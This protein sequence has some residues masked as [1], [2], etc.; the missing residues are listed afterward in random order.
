L[1]NAKSFAKNKVKS[2]SE[3]KL[4]ETKLIIH[5]TFFTFVYDFGC[6]LPPTCI[7]GFLVR[8]KELDFMPN[9]DERKE[10]YICTGG[11]NTIKVFKE[12]LYSSAT[13]P[14]ANN[15]NQAN[16]STLNTLKIPKFEQIRQQESI[17]SSESGT[18]I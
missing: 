1:K 16:L 9:M 4:R 15:T 3:S 7:Y 17:Y 12:K 10:M 8:P 2:G 11:I 6:Q 14:Q 5:S 18:P 13:S